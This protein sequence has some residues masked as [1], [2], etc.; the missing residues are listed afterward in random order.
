MHNKSLKE[1]SIGL[2]NKEF[3]SV[4]LTQV[5]LNRI[6]QH[7]DLNAFITITEEIALQSAKEADIRIANKKTD[8]LTGIPVAQKDHGA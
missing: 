4:E 6:K 1:L 8:S 7:Q 2:Q 3:S 5:F